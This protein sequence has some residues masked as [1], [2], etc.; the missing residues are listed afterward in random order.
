[1]L[2]CSR[3][4]FQNWLWWCQKFMQWPV[5]ERIIFTT[6]TAMAEHQLKHCLW[7]CYMPSGNSICKPRDP[8]EPLLTEIVSVQAAPLSPSNW[9][10]FYFKSVDICNIFMFVMQQNH[11]NADWVHI[12]NVTSHFWMLYIWTHYLNE[13]IM[14]D[15]VCPCICL[16]CVGGIQ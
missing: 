8:L 3:T 14:G 7:K 6:N 15:D 10:Y 11:V 1:M 2:V 12:L 13:L 5:E 4:S 9:S 16:H